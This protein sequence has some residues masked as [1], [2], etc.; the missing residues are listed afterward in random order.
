MKATFV[1]ALLLATSGFCANAQAADDMDCSH[2]SAMNA[3]GRMSA[4][5]TMHSSMSSNNGAMS[6]SDHMSNKQLAKK[7]DASCRGHGGMMVMDAMKDA[8]AH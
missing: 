2:Y 3:S 1:G 8:T 7:V 6:S 5:E 4:V